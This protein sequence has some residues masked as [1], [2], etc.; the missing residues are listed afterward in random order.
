MGKL[1][2]L[3]KDAGL[4]WS[5]DNAPRMGAALA[6]Y[7]IFSLAPT[8]VISIAVASFFFGKE[9]VTGQF[10]SQIEELVGPDGAQAVQTML[11]NADNLGTTS[12]PA[13]VGVVLLF[14]GAMGLF[15]ELRGAM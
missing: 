15:T 2:A 7:A 13:I 5:D 4:A 3:L 8:L 9:A 11:A 10:A 6:D 14:I 12:L 1:I